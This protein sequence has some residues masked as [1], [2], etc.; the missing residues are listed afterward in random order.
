M[1]DHV[2]PVNFYR[3]SESWPAYACDTV[4]GER[5]AVPRTII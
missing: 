5:C 2:V 1:I 4:A 3:I